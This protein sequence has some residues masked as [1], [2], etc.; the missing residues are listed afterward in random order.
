MS[1]AGK[2]QER[3]RRERA[4]KM[5]KLFWWFLVLIVVIG[6]GY[7]LVR[8]IAHRQT[9]LPGVGYSDVGRGHIALNDPTPRGY[10]SNPPVSGPHFSSP[11][12]WGVYDYE[13]RDEIFLHNMEHG[14]VWISY[15]PGVPQGVVDEL[16]KIAGDMNTKIVLEPRS[17][18]DTDIAVAAWTHLL[19]FNLSGSALSASQKEDIKN[20]VES[21]VNKGPEYIPNMGGGVD[22]KTVQ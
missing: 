16:K 21:F 7:G 11:A 17:K 19:K 13:V 6:V 14:G 20:F 9:T 10:N 5:K 3:A 12:N 2:E 15:K 8:W 1:S 4:R 22:P 18:N